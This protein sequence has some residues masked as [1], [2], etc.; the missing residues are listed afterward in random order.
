MALERGGSGE[1]VRRQ[2]PRAVAAR[3]E[4]AN[5]EVEHAGHQ[6]RA[7][8]GDPNQRIALEPI[9]YRVPVALS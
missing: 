7:E 9:A 4:R 6:R 8:H 2:R 3:C 5:H 1:G